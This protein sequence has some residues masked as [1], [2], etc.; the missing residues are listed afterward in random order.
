MCGVGTTDK[1]TG[2]HGDKHRPS[3]DH[4][5]GAA[6]AGQVQSS[7]HQEVGCRGEI[8]TTLLAVWRRH[9]SCQTCAV[10][11][12][13]LFVCSYAVRR[14]VG[15]EAQLARTQTGREKFPGRIVSEMFEEIV[16]FGNGLVEIFGNC[17]GVKYPREYL[18]V[19]CLVEKLFGGELSRG[20]LGECQDP[21]AGL[22]AVRVAVNDMRHLVNT[23]THTDRQLSTSY[24]ISS[25]SQLS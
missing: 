24:T 10:A 19:N 1:S 11:T 8:S 18:G 20:C 17:P 12:V 14:P 2:I 21:H 5:A 16:R 22:Q 13:Y 23:Q 25:A 9:R 4:I 6:F 3:E 7:Q 15:C